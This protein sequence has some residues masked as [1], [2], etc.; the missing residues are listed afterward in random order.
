MKYII[1][2]C[3]HC[4]ELIIIDINEINCKIFRHGM[5]KDTFNQIDPHLDKENCDKLFNDGKIYGC[6]K[7]FELIQSNDTYI[8]IECM[9][10]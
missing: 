9:Y 7:P 3:P 5:Y 4:K 10:K 8:A 6:G 1:I 2:N